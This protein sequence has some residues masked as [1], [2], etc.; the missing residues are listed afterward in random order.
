MKTVLDDITGYRFRVFNLTN[1]ID[2]VGIKATQHDITKPPLSYSSLN[3]LAKQ[4]TGKGFNE[5]QHIAYQTKEHLEW[6]KT[7]KG[8]LS[9]WFWQD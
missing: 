2:G 5:Y 4:M 1:M 9:I 8:R 7:L 3:L 6:S